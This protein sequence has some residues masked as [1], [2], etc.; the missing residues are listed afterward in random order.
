MPPKSDPPLKEFLNYCNIDSTAASTYTPS[1]YTTNNCTIASYPINM[2]YAP[3]AS[4][5]IKEY[6]TKTDAHIDHLEE[7]IEFLN[8]ERKY[9][10]EELKKKDDDLRAAN[11]RIND[12]EARITQLESSRSALAAEVDW[13]MTQL[14][15]LITVEVKV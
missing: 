4:E 14:Q 2:L 5:E 8:E 9:L 12:A 7:D 11:T 13:M 15:K 1:T 10:V 6:T 3:S